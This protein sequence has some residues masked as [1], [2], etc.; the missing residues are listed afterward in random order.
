M[1]ESLKPFELK[2]GKI[3]SE[4][5]SEN[6]LR[7]TKKRSTSGDA[8][9]GVIGGLVSLA[10]T[11]CIIWGLYRYFCRRR[12]AIPMQQDQQQQQQQ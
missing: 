4:L 1:L 5:K 11:I 6:Y 12:R 3:P 2:S 7:R 9:G 8:T 10:V